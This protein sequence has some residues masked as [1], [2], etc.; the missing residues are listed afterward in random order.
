MLAAVFD[1][2]PQLRGYVLDDQGWLRKHV[3]VFVDGT[4]VKDRR[5]LLD[6]VC[7]DSRIFVMQSLSGG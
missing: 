5:H 1:D 3:N 6:E 2:H 7:D 4:M